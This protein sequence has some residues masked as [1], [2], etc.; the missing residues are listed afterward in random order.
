M[1]QRFRALKFAEIRDSLRAALRARATGMAEISYS[2]Q[3][4]KL[5][6]PDGSWPRSPEDGDG[7]EEDAVK[8]SEGEA[9]PHA[10]FLV[11]RALGG[12][13][14]E[15][16]GQLCRRL[17]DQDLAMVSVASKDPTALYMVGFSSQSQQIAESL[18]Q[19]GHGIRPGNEVCGGPAATV[20]AA[21]GL[22]SLGELLLSG[23]FKPQD[24]ERFA[25]AWAELE[26]SAPEPEGEGGDHRTE[27]LRFILQ[28]ARRLRFV[29]R[30]GLFAE[31][32]FLGDLRYRAVAG[33]FTFREEKCWADTTEASAGVKVSAVRRIAVDTEPMRAPSDSSH[34]PVSEVCN[35]ELHD[36]TEGVSWR[37]IAN[38]AETPIAAAELLM[39]QAQG[40]GSKTP[41]F[42]LRAGVW[43]VCGAASLQVLG[44]PR[45]EGLIG[46]TMCQSMEQ[47][48][49]M[50]HP[51]ALS[52]ELQNRYEGSTGLVTVKGCITRDRGVGAA[53][54]A[55]GSLLCGAT[56]KSE[57]G[58][59]TASI[60]YSTGL[61]TKGGS[62]TLESP[63]GS[64]TQVWRIRELEDNPFD[65]PELRAARK[66][67]TGGRLTSPTAA[68]VRVASSM[69]PKGKGKGKS[70][71]GKG[72]PGRAFQASL[73][74]TSVAF[75][76]APIGSVFGAPRALT[77]Y[78]G[79]SVS[80]PPPRLGSHPPGRPVSSLKVERPT[81]GSKGSKGSK[82]KGGSKGDSR[83]I[84]L[85]SANAT[86]RRR[87]R[88]A[89][90]RET[91]ESYK[92]SYRTNAPRDNTSSARRRSRSHTYAGHG[93]SGHGGHG[94]HGGHSRRSRS[95]RRGR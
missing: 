24:L 33:C 26:E 90:R 73:P 34:Q 41:V 50:E 69:A 82:G 20:L 94:G 77:V 35:D 5:T 55:K 72:R 30:H 79:P 74:A 86:P 7:P 21:A 4:C 71:R 93:S 13:S 56:P 54:N 60:L 25:G 83:S 12:A 18:L 3:D 10:E 75:A 80:A 57:I 44:P 31:V 2:K 43:I 15:Q 85:S 8:G 17:L 68:V 22:S 1:E 88:S 6:P 45:G 89:Q 70:G 16:I 14:S 64:F 53:A 42:G 59:K 38:P 27:S 37:R 95:R 9:G 61:M 62:I 39:E 28:R 36:V 81:K 58:F 51:E 76:S 23:S 32:H 29:S 63:S 87:S 49:S 19:E 91:A 52:D 67:P 40:P 11:L 78:G 47:L 84:T 92:G 65:S 66:I 46:G 48:H